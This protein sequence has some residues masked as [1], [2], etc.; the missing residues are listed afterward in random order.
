MNE[1]KITR[2]TRTFKDVIADKITNR[3][4]LIKK[5]LKKFDSLTTELKDLEQSLKALNNEPQ[6]TDSNAPNKEDMYDRPS[7][8]TPLSENGMAV[9]NRLSSTFVADDV[10]RQLDNNKAKA[11]QYIA[12]WKR[13]LF[14]VTVSYGKYRKAG[15]E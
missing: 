2:V 12:A 11:F 5:R 15:T 4:V 8:M 13:S 1:P 9:L 10:A 14:I 7:D 6:V 3:I